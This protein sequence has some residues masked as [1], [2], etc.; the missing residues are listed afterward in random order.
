MRWLVLV[1]MLGMAWSQEAYYPSRDGLSWT[2]NNGETQVLSGVKT[3]GGYTASVLVKYIEGAP[4]AED[5][6]VYDAQGVSMVGT[7]ANGMTLEYTP[8]L[9]IYPVSPLQVGQSWKSKAN[10][11]GYEIT[12][13]AEVIGVRGVETAAG[14]YNALQVR[15]QTITSTG[16]QTITDFFFVPSVGVVRWVMQDGTTIDLIDK[17]F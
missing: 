17:N 16:G 13:T 14:R 8:G 15:Q 5:Y 9:V 3:V 11:S 4:I 6:M 12:I 2:Y 7:A 10:L 1:L